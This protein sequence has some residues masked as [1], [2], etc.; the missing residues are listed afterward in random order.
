MSQELTKS[1]RDYEEPR[2]ETNVIDF[3]RYS[4]N[5]TPS[6]EQGLSYEAEA[7]KV[8][9]NRTVRIPDSAFESIDRE[10]KS[11]LQTAFDLITDA[12][13]TNLG[14]AEKS[15]C[16]D[17]WKDVLTALSRRAESLSR[18]HRKILGSLISSIR[19]MDI[20]DFAKDRLRFFQEAT[21]V[22]R[23]PRVMKLESER[24]ISGCL[25]LGLNVLLPLAM[26]N[27]TGN[28]ANRIEKLIAEILAESQQY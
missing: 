1:A 2:I 21:N 9:R 7:D 3:F 19:V 14:M 17:D 10:T 15:N 12:I 11:L 5:I 18:N 25:D 20:S 26:D 23:Q 28:E 8:V 16:F 24:V 22:L 4:D 27:L 13:D 6:L